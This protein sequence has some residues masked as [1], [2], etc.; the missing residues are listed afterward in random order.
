MISKEAFKIFTGDEVVD[1]IIL[2]INI[3]NTH[4]FLVVIDMKLKTISS[5]NSMGSQRS[6]VL[7]HIKKY[8]TC[9]A[10]TEGVEVTDEWTESWHVYPE[11][12]HVNTTYTTAACSYLLRA[13]RSARYAD[14]L[15]GKLL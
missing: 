14:K 7:S 15:L 6:D 8:L 1:K 4:W 13:M 3:S 5:Y 10:K 9:K 11:V 12:V 2:P